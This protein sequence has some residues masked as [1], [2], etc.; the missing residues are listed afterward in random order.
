MPKTLLAACVT[1]L[2]LTTAGLRGG[3]ESIPLAQ[4]PK[5]VI[6]AVKKRFPAAEMVEAAKETDGDKVEFEVS[7]KDAGT[8]IDVMLTPAGTLTLIE[9]TVPAKDLPKA[10]ADVLEA[11]YPKAT[12]KVVESVTKVAD[13]KET[14]DFY[15]ILLE[16][17]DKKVLEV[18][19]LPDGKAKLV[20]DKTGKPQD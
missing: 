3:E 11:K 18:Q 10:A 9:K 6:D 7:L 19:I 5:A 4:V 2:T 17:A 8:K 16:T 1:A 15:E 12:Y 13:G 14:L 20:E